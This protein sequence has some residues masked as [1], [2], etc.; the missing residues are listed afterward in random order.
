MDFTLSLIIMSNPF[1]KFTRTDSRCMDYYQ[2]EGNRDTRLQTQL[3]WFYT[4]SLIF[5]YFIREK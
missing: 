5:L 3:M 2:L 1:K 4:N